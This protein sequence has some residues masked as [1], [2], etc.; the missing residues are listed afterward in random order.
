MNKKKLSLVQEPGQLDSPVET[1]RGEPAKA[2][3]EIANA[4]PLIEGAE[5]DELVAD[6]KAHGLRN[7]ITLFEDIILDGRNRDRACLL[8]GV[9]PSM[10][11]C[12]KMVRRSTLSFR[13][14]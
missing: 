5:F 6:I 3:H 12:R 9:T 1:G 10:F 2:Y 14:I 11:P 13:R 7:P 8:A 4:F